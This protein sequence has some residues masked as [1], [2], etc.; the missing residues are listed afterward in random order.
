MNSN[1]MLKVNTLPKVLTRIAEVTNSESP[2]N[3][4][5][6]TP[7]IIAVGM[8]NM[9][10]ATCRFNPLR[11][12]SRVSR[13]MSTGAMINAA[14]LAANTGLSWFLLNGVRCS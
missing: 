11:P 6:K 1:N 3:S 2:P 13:A 5:A 10:M 9:V 4:V 8:A 14:P 7:A 12:I